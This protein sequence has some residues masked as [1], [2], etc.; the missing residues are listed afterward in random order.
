MDLIVEKKKK[1][2]KSAVAT[3]TVTASEVAAPPLLQQQ[4][5]SVMNGPPGLVPT[6]SQTE[7]G[8]SV[9]PNVN[10]T[11][12][13]PAA[14]NVSSAT[15]S[16][17][18]EDR[19]LGSKALN[20]DGTD[21]LVPNLIRRGPPNSAFAVARAAASSR[22]EAAKKGGVSLYMYNLGY[23][24][25]PTYNGLFDPFSSDPMALIRGGGFAS[26][27]F[28]AA[29]A[30]NRFNR[31]IGEDEE[32]VIEKPVSLITLT[33]PWTK[34]SISG[35]CTREMLFLSL[36]F[37]M[38]KAVGWTLVLQTRCQISEQLLAVSGRNHLNNSF[39]ESKF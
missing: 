1:V 12:A 13:K 14:S 2:K 24:L 17:P 37:Q 35:I 10:L 3:P 7:V 20:A 21:E 6:K 34:P 39:C 26:D 30:A 29:A 28:G 9:S 27:E 18:D 38:L 33:F 23:I 8:P 4:S 19:V 11:S 36:E 15:S 16:V 22:K 25:N 32:K 5:S 31:I